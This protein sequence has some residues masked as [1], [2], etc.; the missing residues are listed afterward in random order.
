MA[1]PSL[2]LQTH[3]EAT[4]SLLAVPAASCRESQRYRRRQKSSPHQMVRQHGLHV[5][6]VGT[7]ALEN[8]GVDDNCTSVELHADPSAAQ[9]VALVVAVVRADL[10]AGAA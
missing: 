9:R 1:L 8:Y 4:P 5:N 3:E 2:V 7:E 10:F 6:R